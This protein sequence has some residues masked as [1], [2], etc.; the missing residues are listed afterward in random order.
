MLVAAMGVA[1]ASNAAAQADPLEFLKKYPSTTASVGSPNVIV[2]VDLA[3]RMQRDAPSDANCL[4]S[5][6]TPNS[7]TTA[8]ANA[9][10]NYYDSFLYTRGTNVAAETT[11]GVNAMNTTTNYRRKYVNMALSGNGTDKFTPETAAKACALIRELLS[12]P[13]AVLVSG[14]S[15]LGGIDVWAE[16]IADEM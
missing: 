4:P 15:P 2:A 1:C 5:A 3:N 12:A 9:T 14:R 16:E 13:G 6:A 10:S 7:C 11:L 8:V